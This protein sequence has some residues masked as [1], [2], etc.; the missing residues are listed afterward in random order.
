M[1]QTSVL[2]WVRVGRFGRALR[3]SWVT[4]CGLLLALQGVACAG[5][6]GQ[7]LVQDGEEPAATET[8]D[9][10]A[11][12]GVASEAQ[13]DVTSGT[14]MSLDLSPD[15]KTLVFDLLGDLYSLPIEGGQAEPLL[16][17]IAWD[18]Q[19]RF[20]P[21]GKRIAFTSDRGGGDNLWTLELAGGE[22]QQ[23]SSESFRLVNSP[24]WTP[25]GRAIAGRK[26]FT[27]GR[28]LGAGEVWL[29]HQAGSQGVQM[30]ERRSEQKDLGEPAFSP[31]GRYLYYSR[32]STAGSTFEYSKD[33]TGQ[34]YQ[35]DRLDRE[36]GEL[37]AMVG[38][39][40]GA[41]RPTPSPDGKWLAFVR[42]VSFE[43]TLFV[44]DLESGEARS[45]YA[46]L[47]RDMQE[48]WAVHG[49]YPTMAWTP[50]S[51]EIVFYAKGGLKR[52]NPTSGVMREIPFHIKASRELRV[53]VRFPVAVAPETFEVKALQSVVVA[54]AGNAVV[55]QALGHLWTR[56]LPEGTPRRL[57]SD[58]SQFEFFPS[59]SRDGRKLT[60]VSWNDRELGALWVANAD[61][62][63]ARKISSLKGHFANPVFSP[64]GSQVFFEKLRG[65]SLT[66]LKWSYETGIYRVPAAG[67]EASL[68]TR[69]G[70]HPMFA[71]DG[72]ELL[73]TRS[74]WKSDHS[75]R[76]L[77]A[78]RLRDGH[79]TTLFSS[80][81]GV[82]W[83]VSPDGKWLAFSERYK[84]C[85]VPFLK[86][87]RSVVLGPEMKAL[88]MARV[89]EDAG[90]NLQFS[91]DSKRL[92]WSLGP[93][94][95]ERDL[96]D[97]F[98]FLEGAPKELPEPEATGR[99][100]GFEQASAKPSGRY[101]LV[102]ARL[103]TM[104]GDELIE[105]GSILIDGDRIEAIGPS[106]EL[107]LPADLPSIDCAGLTIMPGMLDVHAHGS[108]AEN[109]LTPKDNWQQ[110]A[111]LAFG[112]T[113][114]HDP[115]NDTNAIFAAS[116]MAKAGVLLMPRIYST[117]TI[118]YGAEGYFKAEVGSV[119]DA[120]HHLRRLKA[121]GAIS[122]KSYNQPRREQRQQVLEAARQL[123]MMVVPE[124]GSLFQ[125]NMTMI[126]DGHTGIEHTLPVERVY[127]D[128]LQLWGATPVG[129]TPTHVVCYGGI[130]GENYWYQKLKVWENE[131]LLNFVPRSVVD[132]RSRRRPMAPD[133]DYNHLRAASIAKDLV[134]VGG[135]AQLGAH[136]QLAGY[137]AHWELWMFVQG[138]MTPFEALRAATLDGA[139]YIG[140]DGD[141]GSLEAGKL[142][143]LLVLEA[144]PLSDIRN[145][146][147]IRYTVLGGRLL[148]ART[149]EDVDPATGE[150][151]AGPY[152]HWRESESGVGYDEERASCS[153]GAH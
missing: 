66:S 90:E 109:G 22:P 56:A 75:E 36:T 137:A 129:Y 13:L 87:G 95:F 121:V 34:I 41:C 25:D 20:S 112:V 96:K 130:W 118:L 60:Y 153:C 88:P 54:P 77:I 57:L 78:H 14:W 10:N 55:Y 145:S 143:D 98:A 62:S 85:V 152:Y 45:V 119:D 32:D 7:D 76:T 21:D 132:P 107:E 49:V 108:M 101:A 53:P 48:T 81:N 16:T 120:L 67:G 63:Q 8:W 15:G 31:D 51:S 97:S 19:P 3:S 68:V 104:R 91:G 83:N 144:N 93:E 11:P 136:G 58:D 33:S 131:R 134:R 40:G 9:V 110:Q 79:E 113:T 42:R 94:L 111:N 1:K 4:S 146:E 43:S 92:L 17:G 72:S 28:S 74:E 124:G 38:G 73:L 116:E 141:L 150:R 30:T 65:G 114:I 105:R 103:I 123:E 35:I 99:R 46:P 151:G 86:S 142:A 50:D 47:E 126:V 147:Q 37:R 84:A 69:E 71:L 23:V 115:S 61:G 59:F 24:A 133:E 135:R 117:G 100:I 102:G 106:S 127:E 39:A 80:K 82:E 5:L 122:V 18:M 138:G 27:S 2:E 128:V 89:A 26:H 70:T 29:Y 140:L 139:K 6:H 64:D 149:L 52:V 12:P 148:D 125:H 44:L